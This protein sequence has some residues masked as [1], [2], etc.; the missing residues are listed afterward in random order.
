MALFDFSLGVIVRV[1][2]AVHLA[3]KLPL[4]DLVF[5]KDR[6]YLVRN[7]A[8]VRIQLTLSLVGSGRDGLTDFLLPRHE[9]GETHLLLAND[10]S[11][12]GQMVFGALKGLD[13]RV[14]FH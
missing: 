3:H 1:L 6:C 2:F 12:N 14:E 13:R 9:R 11:R 7:A 4:E 5:L 8:L 10:G